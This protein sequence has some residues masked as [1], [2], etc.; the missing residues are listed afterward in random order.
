[1]RT[2][3]V[4]SGRPSRPATG[5]TGA[6]VAVPRGGSSGVIYTN[7]VLQSETFD[8]GSWTKTRSTVSADATAAP[9]GSTTADSLVEDATATSTHLALQAIT[10]VGSV[11]YCMSVYAKA[12]TRTWIELIEGAGVTASCYFN[13]STGVLGTLSG[14]GAP[15]AQIQAAPGGFF[16][17]SLSFVSS[18]TTANHQVRLATGDTVDSYSG[19]NASKVFLWGAQFQLGAEPTPYIP[20]VAAA[21]SA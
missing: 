1:M 21:V 20:T 13:L 17:C 7:M 15:T 2:K 18:G 5:R 19:D 12:S 6:S 10:V 4:L 9:N 11:R 8:N 16:R 3:R 14:T